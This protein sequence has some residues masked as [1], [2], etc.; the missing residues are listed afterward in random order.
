[1]RLKKNNIKT[2]SDKQRK[3]EE[4]RQGNCSKWRLLQQ[5]FKSNIRKTLNTA[6]GRAGRWW[7]CEYTSC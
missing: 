5:S 4:D 2:A 7:R 3:V 6:G 1:M